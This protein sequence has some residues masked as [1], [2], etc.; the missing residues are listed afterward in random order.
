MRGNVGP[1]LVVEPVRRFRTV[2]GCPSQN[3]IM[4]E[5]RESAFPQRFRILGESGFL[6]FAS[7][8]QTGGIADHFSLGI[9]GFEGQ[10]LLFI[11]RA[12]F[13]CVIHY[14]F[15]RFQAVDDHILYY[16]GPGYKLAYGQEAVYDRVLYSLYYHWADGIA[17]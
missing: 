4:F 14:C 10:G 15:F 7:F 3:E 8:P 11:L 2:S 1:E 17:G 16:P 13:C 6:P 5:F 12:V 9:P